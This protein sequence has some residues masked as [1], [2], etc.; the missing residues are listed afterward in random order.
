MRGESRKD[1]KDPAIVSLR[2]QKTDQ[3]QCEKPVR[4]MDPNWTVSAKACK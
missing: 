3:S 4:V 2:G 1:K